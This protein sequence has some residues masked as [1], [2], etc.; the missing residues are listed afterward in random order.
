V[1]DIFE[2]MDPNEFAKVQE[3]LFN[4][5]ARSVASPHFQVAERALYFWNNEYFCNLISD[6]VE[7]ILPIMFAPLYENS[8]GHWNRTIH[9]MVYNA[10]KLFMEINPQLF[11]ECSHDYTELQST[12]EQR[13]QNRQNKWDKLAEQAKQMQNGKAGAATASARASKVNAP[14]KIDDVDP[15]TQ[16]S[17]KRL[18][19]LKLQ[20]DGSD[21]KKQREH[22]GQSSKR[23]HQPTD[24][25]RPQ[26]A[27]SGEGRPRHDR[28]G[29]GGST[30]APVTSTPQNLSNSLSRG[31]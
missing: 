5:L 4:Q 1:E 10:M 23:R 28:S 9:G 26:R 21:A 12:A 16:D 2:V 8:K 19:A 6:N 13:K 20:D 18:D 30:P 3:P 15:I 14:S 17:Q 11:D 24:D 25:A 27:A 22:E 31:V 7:I 29:S